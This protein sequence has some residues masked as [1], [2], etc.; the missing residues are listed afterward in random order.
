MVV[1]GGRVVVS[2]AGGVKDIREGRGVFPAGGSF[3]L[4]DPPQLSIEPL[5]ALLSQALPADLSESLCDQKI[6]RRAHPHPVNR[7]PKHDSEIALVQ[8]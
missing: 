2:H 3:E 1:G 5:D 4:Q 8:G 7:R 6:S